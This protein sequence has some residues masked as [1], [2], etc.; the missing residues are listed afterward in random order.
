LSLYMPGL[1]S[2]NGKI[3]AGHVAVGY[4]GVLLLGAAATAIGLFASTL[5][6]S[7]ILAIVLGALILV[8][9][10]LLWAL[11]RAVDPPL[12][13]F[14]SWLAL[15]HENFRA[16]MVGRLELARVVYYVVMTYLFLLGAIKVLEARRWR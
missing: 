12:N 8:P 4:L 6:R 5:A 1:I 9:L 2:V 7:Q 3:S 15:H 14:L 10:L 13:T 11:A 16:F